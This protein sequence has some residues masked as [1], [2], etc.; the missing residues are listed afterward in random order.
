MFLPS[1]RLTK[2]LPL[3]VALLSLVS[4]SILV[5]PTALIT[6]ALIALAGGFGR[7]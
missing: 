6:Y 5:R 4:L 2:R 3:L 7:R 1:P